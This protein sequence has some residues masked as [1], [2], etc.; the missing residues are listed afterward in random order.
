M[1]NLIIAAVFFLP[2]LAGGLSPN[3]AAS[4]PDAGPPRAKAPATSSRLTT[5]LALVDLSGTTLEHLKRNTTL[6][7]TETVTAKRGGRTVKCDA[8]FA[9]GDRLGCVKVD[10]TVTD[11]AIDTTGHFSRTEWRSTIQ[12]CDAQP[13]TVGHAD[14]VRVRISVDRQ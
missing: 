9:E 14:Q 1:R 3:A 11:R 13:L 4:T 7:T 6:G 8:A 12:L 5:E 10:L 2:T